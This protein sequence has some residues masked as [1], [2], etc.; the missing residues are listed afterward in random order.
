MA[1]G[2]SA[3]WVFER[4]SS[5]VECEAQNYHVWIHFVPPKE[6]KGGIDLCDVRVRVEIFAG[7]LVA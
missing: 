6:I 1:L 4:V 3:A 2:F 5:R 7:P